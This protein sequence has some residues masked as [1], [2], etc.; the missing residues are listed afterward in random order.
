[1]TDPLTAFI[2]AACVP[3]ES[4]HATGTLDSA[5]AILAAHPDIAAGDI[6]AAAILGDDAAVR[7]LL[8]LDRGNA[9]VT[10]GPRGWDA[11][12][13]L[14]FSRYLQLDRARSAGFV[15][16]ATALLDAGASANTG[17][18]EMNHRPDPEWESALYG[19]AGVAHH[20]ELTRLLLE[21]GADPNDEETPYHAP[22][23]Y[24]N[25]AVQE[26]VDSGKLS[27]DSLATM[28]LRKADWHDY[29]G[30]K[31]LLEHGADPN[32][33]TR[34]HHTALQHALRRDNALENIELLLDH[35]ADAT[36]ANRTDGKSAVAMAA[37]RGRGDVLALLERRGVAVELRGV[38]GLIAACARNDA[39]RVQSIA[40][41]EP[42]LARQLVAEGGRLLAEFAGIGSTDGLRLL[43]E[44]GVDVGALYKEGDGYWDIAPDS[45]ALHVAAWRARHETV[46]LLLERGAAVNA[47]DGRG[48]T[49]LA[50]AVRACVDSYWTER[51]SPESVAALLDAGA[52]VAGVAVPSGYA[53]VDD[54]LRRHPTL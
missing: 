34:W 39:A 12:T 32:R 6:H 11:L 25:G 43:L 19:A 26:L 24:D 17:W 41:H 50:L 31:F 20:A 49:P 4:G 3:L 15:R 46:K 48:R 14:C 40:R 29:D 2:D 23:T 18:Y 22:E 1:M 44:L 52:S 36:L 16:A 13:H 38:D 35:G 28:L 37:R 7:R 21:R 51:R 33:M 47:P 45:S 27:D 30:S 5:E 42:S 53:E 10:R 9:T 8:E 54:L